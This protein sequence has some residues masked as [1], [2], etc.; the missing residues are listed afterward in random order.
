M[1]LFTEEIES[2]LQ[3]N[4]K[5]GSDMEQMVYLKIFNPY[6]SGTWY[7]M[8]Q[9][10]NDTDYLWAVV[11]LF[12]VECGSVS[13]KEL[14]DIRV[15]PLELPLERDM[16]FKPMKAIEIYNKLIAGETV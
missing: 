15:P 12:E 6:G 1:E 9:D 4:Y 2:K 3:A 11:N 8:N 10:P 13:K 7:I 5:F 14:V 16:H